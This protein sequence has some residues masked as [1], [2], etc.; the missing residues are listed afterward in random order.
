MCFSVC[1]RASMCVYSMHVKE[2]VC[3]MSHSMEFPSP[4]QKD[5]HAWNPPK[6]AQ[7]EKPQIY[8]H[9]ETRKREKRRKGEQGMLS[10]K[11]IDNGK[12]WLNKYIKTF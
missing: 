6:E 3:S 12:T 1:K 4:F 11:V 5:G 8:S 9:P 10:E 7:G 2:P